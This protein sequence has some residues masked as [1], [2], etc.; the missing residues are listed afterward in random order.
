VTYVDRFAPD[1]F[2]GTACS[3]VSQYAV[4]VLPQEHPLADQFMVT[5]GRYGTG[6]VVQTN[7][8][9][10]TW[11]DNDPT[12][13]TWYM[14]KPESPLGDK[15]T[16]YVFDFFNAFALAWK[17][18]RLVRINGRTALDILEEEKHGNDDTPGE[19]VLPEPGNPGLEPGS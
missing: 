7:R 14:L 3:W 6:W 13:I 9:Q 4:S 17:V 12:N 15:M 11:R 1:G 2:P 8:G 10:E 16:C 18:A 5:V 19:A